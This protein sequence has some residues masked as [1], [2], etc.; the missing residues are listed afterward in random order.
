MVKIFWFRKDLRLFDNRALT[1]FIDDVKPGEKFLFLY[2]KN[3]NSFTYFGEMRISFLYESLKDL[4]NTLNSNGLN[5]H[6]IK[7]NS[8]SIFKGLQSKHRNISVYAN[9]QIE[10]Y[11]IKRDKEVTDFLESKSCTLK[12]F[13]DT[14]LFEPD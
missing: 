10:S 2:V 13:T 4:N 6:I 7:G 3:R 12:L 14:T 1:H 5:L 9:R 8:L 11:S